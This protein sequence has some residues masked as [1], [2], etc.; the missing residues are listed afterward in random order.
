MEHTIDTLEISCL[1]EFFEVDF[2]SFFIKLDDNRYVG[3]IG[4]DKDNNTFRVLQEE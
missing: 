2:E 1:N 3:V 4:V